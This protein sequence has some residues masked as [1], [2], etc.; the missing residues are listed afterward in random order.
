SGTV[1]AGDPPALGTFTLNINTF[2]SLISQGLSQINL[3]ATR[4]ITLNANTTWTLS[5]SAAPA[6]LTLTAGNN[7]TL[8]NGSAIKAGKNWSLDL[9]A[10]TALAAGSLPTTG[11]DAILLSGTSY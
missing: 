8:N 3:A 9:T 7:I 10:G 2:S 1:N 6:S 5:D 11:N 4:N